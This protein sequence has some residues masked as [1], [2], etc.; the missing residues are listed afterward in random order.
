MGFNDA[1]RNDVE[2]GDPQDQ[3]EE[4]KEQ[5]LKSY[6]RFERIRKYSGHIAGCNAHFLRPCNCG[7]SQ[8]LNDE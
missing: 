5:L 1:I 8:I 4:L 6:Q 2:A 3:I 7:L